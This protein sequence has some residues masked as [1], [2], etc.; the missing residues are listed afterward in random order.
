MK[1]E[2][3]TYLSEKGYKITDCGTNIPPPA[4]VDYPKFAYAVAKNV[5]DGLSEIGIIIDGAGIGSAMTANKVS[6]VELRYAMIYQLLTMHV[7]TIMPT[8]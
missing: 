8:Y 5:A 2:L 4:S 6:G 1:K 3:K 7:N